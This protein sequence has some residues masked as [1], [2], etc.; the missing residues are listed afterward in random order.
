MR[1]LLVDDDAN[2]L[3]GYQRDRRVVALGIRP[4]LSHGPLVIHFKRHL[5]AALVGGSDDMLDVIV[6][7]A[8][9]ISQLAGWIVWRD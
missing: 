3:A 4:R 8:C 2:T 1:L 7:F 6:A 9:N 5:F